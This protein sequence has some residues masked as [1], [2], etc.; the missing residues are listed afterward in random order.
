MDLDCI[1]RVDC[2]QIGLFGLNNVFALVSTLAREMDGMLEEAK[3]AATMGISPREVR[4]ASGSF[5]TADGRDV[6]N[7]CVVA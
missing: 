1:Y 4:F 3:H 6:H 7:F 5:C 2:G